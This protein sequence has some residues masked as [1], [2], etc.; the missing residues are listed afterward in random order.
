LDRSKGGNRIRTVG[1]SVLSADMKFA[2]AT[3]GLLVVAVASD[4][5]EI[6]LRRATPTSLAEESVAIDV[7][8][9]T[10]TSVWQSFLHSVETTLSKPKLQEVD[11]GCALIVGLLMLLNGEIVFKWIAVVAAGILVMLVAMSEL[12]ARGFQDQHIR[13]MVALEVFLAASYTARKGLGGIMLGI[14][15]LFGFFLAGKLEPILSLA[16]H[17][18]P[19][20]QD[21]DNLHIITAVWYSI[22]V[23]CGIGAVARNGYARVL[24]IIASICGGALVSSAVAWIATMAL[25]KLTFM[26]QLM[27]DLAPGRE[28][29]WYKFFA[30]LV[31]SDAED[32]GLFANTPSDTFSG[33]W[34]L[35]RVLGL[36]L[37]FLLFLLGTI[38][39]FNALA[40]MKKKVKASET[41][42][43]SKP[44]L[45]EGRL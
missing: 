29:P 23:L 19:H 45:E 14:G 43:L 18:I 4:S 15:A 33:F 2:F 7:S 26:S 30:L 35:D 17:A 39:Q 6:A 5:A 38:K 13:N 1:C 12:S 20:A 9:D 16:V 37:W 22:F 11:A 32:V 36:S 10:V 28:A 25:G 44:L 3:L 24:A 34:N 8:G 27:P 21:A 31:S 40:A 41:T 42:T